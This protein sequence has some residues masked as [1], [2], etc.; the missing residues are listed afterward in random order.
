MRDVAHLQLY[1]VTRSELRI[2]SNVEQGEVSRFMGKLEPHANGQVSQSVSGAFRPE[3]FPLFQGLLVH[4][5]TTVF[6]GFSQS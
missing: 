5:V 4:L 6:M 1:Q 3:N 2:D